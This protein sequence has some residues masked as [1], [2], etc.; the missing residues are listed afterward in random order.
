MNIPD[1]ATLKESQRRDWNAVASG[2][3]KWWPTIEEGARHVS[4]RL[5][6]AA[7]IQSGH[8]VL[9]IATGIGEPAVSAATRF[10]DS[11]RI[12]AADQAADMLAI[13]RKRAAGLNLNNIEFIE[14]DGEQLT[15]SGNETV[16]AVLCRW[17]LMFMPDLDQALRSIHNTLAPGGRLS[18]AVWST[19]EK[20]PSISFAMKFVR[21]RLDL[22][23]PPANMPGPFCLADIDALSARMSAAGFSD[24]T[25]DRFGVTF[26]MPSAEAFTEFTREIAA[27]VASM[28]DRQP[29]A[30]RQQIWDEL[31]EAIKQFATADGRIEIENECICVCAVKP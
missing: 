9:D 28:V 6:D 11:I 19:P 16:H 5:I 4:Q 31:T 3:E 21:Q 10:G 27:P 29:A 8:T 2:W 12:I 24:I 1:N 25:H 14:M 22:P 15:L 18:T 30:E 20:T 17:G 13:A 7:Q 23:P 26:A